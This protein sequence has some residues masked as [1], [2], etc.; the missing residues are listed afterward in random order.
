MRI[1]TLKRTR[2]VASIALI[3]VLSVPI[4]AQSTIAEAKCQP[5]RSDDRQTYFDGW[6]RDVGTRVG[7]VYSNILNYSPWVQPGVGQHTVGWSMLANQSYGINFGQIGWWEYPGT[8]GRKTF[9]E[10]TT[11]PNVVAPP[12]FYNGD[13]VGSSSYYTV[14][15]DEVTGFQF[16]DNGVT[17]YSM[18]AYYTPIE[19]QIFGEMHTL[20][21]QMPGGV[22]GGEVFADSHVWIN[23]WTEFAG[24]DSNSPSTYFGIADVSTTQRNIWDR[25]CAF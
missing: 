10:Y 16:K 23:N 2:L 7:G 19:A 5:G 3:A 6:R 25:S 17:E 9:V 4:I 11:S 1:Q 14:L 13:P 21:S 18:P 8:V 12:R 20:A 24:S 15:Y 22:Y